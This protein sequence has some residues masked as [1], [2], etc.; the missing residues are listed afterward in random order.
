MGS[1]EM[2]GHTTTAVGLRWKNIQRMKV[3]DVFGRELLALILAGCMVA[4]FPWIERESSQEQGED[5]VRRVDCPPREGY[6]YCVGVEVDIASE[7]EKVFDLAVDIEGL[8]RFFPQYRFD[9]DCK[10]FAEGCL[11]AVAEKGKEKVLWY[12]IVDFDDRSYYIGEL[13]SRDKIFQRFRYEHY[14]IQKGRTTVS[15]EYVYY[16]L[17][18]GLIGRL[19]Q[20]VAKRIILKRLRHAHAALK[21]L[22]ET[23]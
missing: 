6:R 11:Y 19:L 9:S 8:D 10:R 18:Y 21:K 20:P 3:Q 12:E 23:R 17:R 16:S 13:R 4:A 14:F 2:C 22:A 5:A 7:V 1:K 15:R